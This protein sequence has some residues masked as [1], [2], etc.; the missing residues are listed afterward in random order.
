M[1]EIDEFPAVCERCCGPDKH[2]KMIRQPF[3]EECKLC[4]RPFTVFR[5]NTRD[6]GNKSKKTIICQTCARSKNCCQSCM[7]DI[8]YLIPL[9]LRDAALKMA[10]IDNTLAIEQGSSSNRE[11]KAIMADKMESRLKKED[12]SENSARARDILTKLAEKLNATESKL[13]KKSNLNKKSETSD[14]KN[15]DVS[16]ILSKLPFGGL[17]KEPS[18]P[19]VTSFFIFGI[20][21]DVPQYTISDYC[22]K[23]GK[24]KN[25]T[26]VHNAKCGFISFTSRKS[27]ESFAQAIRNNGL[28]KDNKKA[29]LLLLDNKYPV[30]VTWGN[31]KPLGRTNEEH[32]KIGLVVL[33]VLK[34]LAE[35]K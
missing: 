12:E 7:L 20:N 17:L 18:D 13:N 15:V 25:M 27:A 14:I 8:T 28:N 16:K 1:S 32:K 24:T 3:G 10:G 22:H 34:Q 33:K 26:I 19:S 29:G 6:S 9:E 5:W 11:V 23:F 35:K 4:T 30:R 21:A 2:I 31:P